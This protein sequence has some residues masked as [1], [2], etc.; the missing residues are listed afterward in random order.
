MS[1]SGLEIY[2]LL[3]KT[4]CRKCGYS[5]CLA[6]AMALAKNQVSLDKCPSVSADV[7]AILEQA[8][9]AAMRIVTIGRGENKIDVGGETVMFRH[10]EKF[11]HPTAVGFIIEDNI[12]DSDLDKKIKTINSLSFERVGEIIKANLIA[13]KQKGDSHNFVDKIKKITDISSLPLVLMSP[14]VQVLKSAL[15]ICSKNKP[16]LY[17]ACEKNIDDFIGLAKSFN[18]SLVISETDLEKIEKLTQKAAQA[19][20]EDVILDTGS[21]SKAKKIQD[22]TFIRRLAL[23]KKKRTLGYPVIAVVDNSEIFQEAIEAATYIAKYASIVLIK[24][25]ESWHTLALLTLRQNIFTD[26]QKPLQVEPKVYE[27]GQVSNQSPLMVTTNFS[28]TYYTVL[29]EVEASKIPSYIISVDTEGMSVLT[30]W[31]AEKFT[32]EKISESLDKSGIKERL[33]H[34]QIIIPG[35]V[36]VMSGDLEEKSGWNVIV[37]PKEASGIPSFLKKL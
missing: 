8:S 13:L 36:S 29:G 1:L 2:K 30:A 10:E 14:D 20:L 11:Y 27:V 26:P 19:G 21:K 23:K 35:Y 15:E 24:T 22:L 5:T 31:A 34:K 32:S 37:G 28:L 12:S 9:L 4:N 6:F 3:A 16:L 33:A 25:I 7:K 17:A 18:V